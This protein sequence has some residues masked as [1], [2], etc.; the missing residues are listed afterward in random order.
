M[1]YYGQKLK[2]F[3]SEIPVAFNP[4]RRMLVWDNDFDKP[5][6]ADIFAY[7]PGLRYP[8]IT[9][10]TKYACCAEIPEPPKPRRA[11]N[12]ELAQWLTQGN[13][14]YLN[15]QSN[16]VHNSYSY[17]RCFE[18]EECHSSVQ[19]RKLDDEDWHEPTADYMGLE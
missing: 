1:K 11:T 12:R 6:E 4:P 3:T 18:E 15:L 13:G 8:A 16:M 14:E 7:L 17:Q 19:V 10:S 5:R 9:E 2:K